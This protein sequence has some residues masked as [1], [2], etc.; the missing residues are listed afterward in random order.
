MARDP[1]IPYVRGR[2]RLRSILGTVSLAATLLIPAAAPASAASPG[3]TCTPIEGTNSCDL[4]VLAPTAVA[5]ASP[6]TVTVTVVNVAGVLASGD[7]CAAKLPVTLEISVYNGGGGGD[8]PTTAVS[9]YTA[10]KIASGATVNF[11]VPGL[12]DGTFEG[13]TYRV[14]ASYA[15]PTPDTCGNAYDPG[16]TYVLVFYIPPTDAIAPCPIG[17]V[18]T[19]TASGTGSAATLAAT[20]GSFTDVYWTSEL[21]PSLGLKPR[22]SADCPMPVN[23]DRGVLNF[24]FTGDGPKAVVF[25]LAPYLLSPKRGISTYNVCWAS[26][27]TFTTKSGAPATEFTYNS[28]TWYYGLLPDCRPSVPAPCVAFR[29][30]N[31]RNALFVG[32]SAPPASIGDPKGY[33]G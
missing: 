23:P 26:P 6:F 9:S 20:D 24:T 13:T 2:R 3:A 22:S 31:K 17:S 25:A 21:F 5:A 15:G 11:S 28:V 8:A 18:C 12:T 32:V 19:Q 33:L 14:A 29:K 7:R 1:G 16:V 30:S 4:V 10:T 27:V